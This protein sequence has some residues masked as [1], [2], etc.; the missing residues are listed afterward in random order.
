MDLYLGIYLS[1]DIT[2]FNL[3]NQLCSWYIKPFYIDQF[4]HSKT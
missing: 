3:F 2:N 1:V 4:G